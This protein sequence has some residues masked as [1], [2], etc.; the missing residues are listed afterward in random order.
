[1][2]IYDVLLLTV[3][4]AETQQSITAG[5]GPDTVAFRQ[6]ESLRRPVV[7]TRIGSCMFPVGKRDL[8]TL[9]NRKHCSKGGQSFTV[10]TGT[11]QRFPPRCS[12]ENRRRRAVLDG[13]SEI[14]CDDSMHKIRWKTRNVGSRLPF[15]NQQ[16]NPPLGS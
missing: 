13:F 15:R 5:V 14:P 8:P 9:R 16:D 11:G 7:H 1:M 12:K 6:K 10:P 3:L 2:P 4:S